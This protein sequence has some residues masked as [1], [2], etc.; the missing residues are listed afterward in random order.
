MKKLLIGAASLATLAAP[1][2]ASADPYWG[3]HGDYG[4]GDYGRGND[5]RGDYRG[6]YDRDRGD[7]AGAAIAAGLFGFVLGAALNH[8][9]SAYDYNY[10]YGYGYGSPYAVR[11]HWATRAYEGPWGQVSYQQ[12]RVC[13]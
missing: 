13:R 10:G 8:S 9:H 2:A 4:R 3:G 11:C 7:D 12:V 5:Y 1:M 6:G